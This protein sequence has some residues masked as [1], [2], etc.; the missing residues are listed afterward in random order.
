MSPT[1]QVHHIIPLPPL[2]NSP[3]SSDSPAEP[4]LVGVECRQ[5]TFLP[6]LSIDCAV[7]TIAAAG[8]PRATITHYT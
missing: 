8:A 3:V 1:T 7:D 4:P 5:I 2:P 6:S